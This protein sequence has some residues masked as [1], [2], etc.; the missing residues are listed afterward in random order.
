MLYAMGSTPN[1]DEI[2]RLA[3]ASA[4]GVALRVKVVPGSSRTAVRGVLADR[5]KVAV[6]APPEAG[7]ANEA[8]CAVLAKALGVPRR[9]VAVGSGARRAEKTV[10]VTGIELT[11]AVEGLER[12]LAK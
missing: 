9:Q 12:L 5:L 3:A 7:K 11:Q 10:R 6:A 4:D 2:C 1:H 8:L